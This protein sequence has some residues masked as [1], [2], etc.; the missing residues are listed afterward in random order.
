MAEQGSARR[1]G[2]YLTFRLAE[3]E[4]GVGILSVREIIGMMPVTSL[5]QAPSSVLGV[6]NLRGR[7]IPI[8]DLRRQFAMAATS[9]TERT[10]I[11][12]VEKGGNG[13]SPQVVGV[14]VDAVSEV[15]HVRAEDIEEP[16]D[17]GGTASEAILG[18]AKMD[19]GIKILLDIDK[20]LSGSNDATIDKAA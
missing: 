7:V 9:Y 2:K 8:I 20:A 14:V 18:M 3:D 6:M 13:S 19:S 12:V 4:Y 11:V 17:F 10:C 15:L 1:E 5:P 16:S